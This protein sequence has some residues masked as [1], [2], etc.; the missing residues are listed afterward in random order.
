NRCSRTALETTTSIDESGISR[1]FS[2]ALNAANPV[3]GIGV[4]LDQ[5]I[6]WGK[7]RRRVVLG[8]CFAQRR[9][10][11]WMIICVPVRQEPVGDDWAN[12]MACEDQR[13][14]EIDPWPEFEHCLA[15]RI[16]VFR[17]KQI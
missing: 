10:E 9:V 8:Q 1:R 5:P 4:F 12:T 16:D 7:I 17:G 13:A 2:A 11:F 14:A 15:A 6:E 3:I